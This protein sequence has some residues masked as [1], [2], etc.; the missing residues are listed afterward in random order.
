MKNKYPKKTKNEKKDIKKQKK[1]K[2][3][4]YLKIFRNIKNNIIRE[5]QPDNMHKYFSMDNIIKKNSTIYIT[6]KL[7][8]QKKSKDKNGK[9]I[10]EYNEEGNNKNDNSIF[11]RNTNNKNS[12]T[13]KEIAISQPKGE[14]I[15]SKISI[16]ND[17]I[18]DN[19]P[20]EIIYENII[21]T[22]EGANPKGKH[23]ITWHCINYRKK[24]NL[25]ETSKKI[26]QCCYTRYKKFRESFGN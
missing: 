8:N 24:R 17:S 13:K 19:S 6:N 11:E 12:N 22:I 14:E 23:R 2:K 18:K 15:T 26:L 3:V 25:P 1:K 7:L 16:I 4:N 21:F 5:E 20:Y 9:E 10:N